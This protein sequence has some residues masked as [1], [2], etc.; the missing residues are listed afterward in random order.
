MEGAA[1][2]LG[3]SRRTLVDVIKRHPHFET[4]GAR[5]I[6]YPEHIEALRKGIDRCQGSKQ[7][8]ARAYSMQSAPSP[9][10]AF[11][12]ALALVTQ[13]SR[14]NLGPSTKRSFGNVVPMGK[15]QS[16]PSRKP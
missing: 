7:S 10:S 2:I 9:G 16:E 13:S 8:D 1:I 14:R 6:F 4:R 12:R 3:I 15:K 11:E 5:K